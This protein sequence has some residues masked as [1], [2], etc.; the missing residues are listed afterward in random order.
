[1]PSNKSTGPNASA[2]ELQDSND[3]IAQLEARLEVL[4]ATVKLKSNTI[5]LL[6]EHVD[7][8]ED[9]LGSAEQ[10]QRRTSLRI[11]GVKVP[12]GAESKEAVLKIVEDAHK[13]VKV[14]FDK[15]DIS[16][17]HRIGPK[18]AKN[19]VT[20][21]SVIVKFNN[22]DARCAL[23]RARPTQ[24]KPVVG[25]KFSSIGLDLTRDRISLLERARSLITLNGHDESVYPFADVNCNLVVRFGEN[26]FRHFANKTQLEAMFEVVSESD[27]NS[28]A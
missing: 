20:T 12:E 14:P 10:Y 21:Q 18:K 2:K 3:K 13:A 9:R 23:Y 7:K 17:C 6:R 26:D 1:M 25:K 8:L 16:R 24:K 15:K 5:G 27:D 22:W 28:A 19:N 11:H 4:E